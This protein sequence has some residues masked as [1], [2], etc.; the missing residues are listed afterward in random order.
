MATDQRDD[1]QLSSEEL[2]KKYNV[3]P[4]VLT[5]DDIRKMAP[6]L[7]G[8]E[9][10]VN[11]LLHWL[12][13]DEVNRV[14]GRW[15]QTPGA[16]FVKHLVEDDFKFKM[17]IDNQD[18]LDRFKTGPFITVSNHPFGAVDGITLIYLIT[19][20]RPDYKVMVNYFL[21]H[22]SAMRPNFISVDA[23]SI[24]PK[25][26]SISINGIREVFRQLRDGHPIG[27][28][29]AGAMSKTNMKGELIDRPWQKSVLEI[30]S[31]AKVPV[32]PIFFHGSNSWL[33][34]FLGHACWPARSLRLP[35][36]VFR[37]RNKE[38]HIS[39]GNPI[40]PE[41]QA[42]YKGNIEGLGEMLREKTYQL[43]NIYS[44]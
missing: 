3:R 9:K 26:R 21:S 2:I 17:R 22:L 12:R 42:Q 30:I 40:M 34:N 14:H 4:A 44:K 29:P 13:V 41:E 16:E 15:S 35:S 38:V 10:L 6:K 7:E 18:I 43:R 19:R 33:F 31:R 32:I 39:I 25:K 8:H 11:A 27:F 23:W 5:Y 36:E 1:S 24:D 28:F 20:L 37:K